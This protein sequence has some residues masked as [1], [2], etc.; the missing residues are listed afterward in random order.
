MKRKESRKV[1]SRAEVRKAHNK[2]L[3]CW[4]GP[5]VTP[6]PWA[7]FSAS[8]KAVLGSGQR[9]GTAAGTA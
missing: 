3:I 7:M 4:P 6:I 5:A 8:R 2:N 1:S 9:V